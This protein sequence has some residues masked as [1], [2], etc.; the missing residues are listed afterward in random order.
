MYL[1]MLYPICI[2]YHLLL[3]WKLLNRFDNFLALYEKYYMRNI[4]TIVYCYYIDIY[5]L[6]FV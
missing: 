4:I 1:L 3:L 5:I 6:R 2:N